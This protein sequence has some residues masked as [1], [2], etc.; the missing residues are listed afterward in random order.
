MK[1]YLTCMLIVVVGLSCG[2]KESTPVI[3]ENIQFDLNVSQAA[4]SMGSTYNFRATL[5]S[6]LP[7]SGVRIEV[8]AVEESGGAAVTPQPAPIT[9]TTATADLTLQ[10]LP[11][12]KW[13]IATVRVTSANTA[14]NTGDLS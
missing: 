7:R 6:K 5:R 11:R 9:A 13:V 1:K 12:Q 2:K 8:S 10:N 3:E 14:T 4:I